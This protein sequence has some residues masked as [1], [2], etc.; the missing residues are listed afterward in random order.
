MSG[1]AW[2][3]QEHQGA[4]DDPRMVRISPYY[5]AQ[6]GLENIFY[7]P[8][9]R[10]LPA[11]GL[12][13]KALVFDFGFNAGRPSLGPR[14]T[15]KVT[16]AIERPILFWA[17]AGVTNDQT[18]PY[19]GYNFNIFHSHQGNKRQFFNKHVA[20]GEIAGAGGNPQ[21]MRMPYMVIKGDEVT[22]EVK[23]LS[24]NAANPDGGNAS[25]QVVI[26]GGE[27]D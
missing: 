11:K 9:L 2:V 17:I 15:A 23:N 8:K 14:G 16:L 6:H 26:Y 12:D 20:D 7:L 13:F 22:C 4:K 19:I 3:G 10:D 25:I 5:F 24:N 18:V 27:F 21:I 1:N